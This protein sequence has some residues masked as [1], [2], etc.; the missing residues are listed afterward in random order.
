MAPRGRP[1]SAV[2]FSQVHFGMSDPQLGEHSA[3]PGLVS[4]DRNVVSGV[5]QQ[6]RG[7]HG[8][9]CPGSLVQS[10][11]GVSTSDGLLTK[12]SA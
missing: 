11:A 8:Q 6:F 1:T 10:P 9:I 7:P 3:N 4:G 12:V 5:N 2:T